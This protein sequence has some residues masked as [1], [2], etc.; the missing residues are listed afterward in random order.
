MSTDNSQPRIGLIFRVGALAI[1]TLIAVRGALGAYFDSVARA[2]ELRKV[3]EAKPGQL[4]NLRADEERRL[5]SGPM[6]IG[7]AM[8]DLAKRG[9]MNA[10]PELSPTTSHDVS[11]LIGWAKMPQAVPAPMMRPPPAPQGDADAGAT[12]IDGAAA[13]SGAGAKAGSLRPASADAGA[14]AVAR[15]A[16]WGR[17]NP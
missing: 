8:H 14:A 17:R 2:E 13:S 1:I 11:P 3:G 6:P 15:D 9:R 10:S 4:L 12:T 7:E 16:G 5:G